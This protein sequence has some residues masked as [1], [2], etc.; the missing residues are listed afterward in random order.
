MIPKNEGIII[1]KKILLILLLGSYSQRNQASQN[2][3]KSYLA[4]QALQHLIKCKRYNIEINNIEQWKKHN[5]LMQEINLSENIDDTKC[6]IED[7]QIKQFARHL[8][9]HFGQSAVFA[10]A[11]RIE[12]APTERLA[13]YE[14]Q[15]WRTLAYFTQNRKSP[16]VTPQEKNLVQY[17]LALRDQAHR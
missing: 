15:F 14:Q 5:I 10:F 17:I 2:Q 6:L 16:K 13:I 7:A 11:Q 3:E 1:M 9:H 4:P 8:S 12:N